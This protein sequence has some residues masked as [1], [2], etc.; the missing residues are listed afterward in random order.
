MVLTTEPGQVERI[1]K[2]AGMQDV[3]DMADGSA[4]GAVG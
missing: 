4:S 2:V 3:F 1:L